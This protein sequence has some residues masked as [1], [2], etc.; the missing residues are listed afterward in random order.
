MIGRERETELSRIS[1]DKELETE[2]RSIAEVIRE[3]IAVDK[4]VAE[5]EEN[6]KK[7]RVVE[8]AQRTR[9]AIVIRA[10]AEAQENLVK[11]IK[12]AEASEQAAKHKAREELTLA[13]AR[14]QTAELETRAKIRLAEGIQA[15]EAAMRPRRGAG[16]GARRRRAGEGRPRRSDRRTREGD[17]DRRGAARQAEG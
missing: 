7:L 3:R 15:E 5:Q 16:Q 14:Q 1:K 12:A 13:E 8:E 6:I 17:R 2:K 4:T 9:E 10:E 11:G